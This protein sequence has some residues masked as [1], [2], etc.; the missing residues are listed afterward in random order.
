MSKSV[1]QFAL[2]LVNQDGVHAIPV[3]CCVCDSAY[4][5]GLRIQHIP[6][7]VQWPPAG[8]HPICLLIR[9]YF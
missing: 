4:Q 5:T 6:F 8:G 7:G 3:L 2:K 9:Q 1:A